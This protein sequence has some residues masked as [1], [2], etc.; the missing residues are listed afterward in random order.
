MNHFMEF[1]AASNNKFNLT[2]TLK[3]V[4]DGVRLN[5]VNIALCPAQIAQCRCRLTKCY[6]DGKRHKPNA[7][8]PTSRKGE[9][10]NTDVMFS[11][12]TDLWSTPQEYFDSVSKEFQFTLDVCALPENTKCQQ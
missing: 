1:R 12:A 5:D 11:S 8:M 2:M 4:V 3:P 7:L 6:T 9:R 10:V